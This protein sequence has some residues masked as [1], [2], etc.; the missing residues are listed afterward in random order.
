MS[1]ARIKALDAAIRET[2]KPD[3]EAQGF[4]Y[5]AGS[6]TFRKPV[7]ECTQVINV[8]V[9]VRSMEGRFTINLGVYHPSHRSGADGVPPTKSPKESDCR[10]RK[11]LGGL[12]DTFFSKFFRG[13]VGDDAN[14][15][16][17][18]LATPSDKWWSFTSDEQHNAR[19]LSSLKELLMTRGTA[20]LNSK[21]HLAARHDPSTGQGARL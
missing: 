1:T 17:W 20:W 4:K 8:Q 12:R 19:Q 15:L 21:S 14:F 7:G 5:E 9:G 18:W 10:E 13:E 11:R 6:R 16:K 2:L 3:L